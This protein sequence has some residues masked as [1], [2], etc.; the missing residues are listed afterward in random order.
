MPRHGHICKWKCCIPV[1]LRKTEALVMG[2]APQVL[3]SSFIWVVFVSQVTIYY[4]FDTKHNMNYWLAFF[5]QT[6]P[7]FFPCFIL[8]I[9]FN[10]TSVHYIILVTAF[11][12]SPHQNGFCPQ[13]R[14]FVGLLLYPRPKPAPDSIHW[15]MTEWRHSQCRLLKVNTT[16]YFSMTEWLCCIRHLADTNWDHLFLPAGPER[17]IFT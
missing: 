2:F 8:S 1:L 6:L 11:L 3:P 12:H 13:N 16:S 14:K 10:H 7:V 15:P 4:H 9:A 5:R 17:W